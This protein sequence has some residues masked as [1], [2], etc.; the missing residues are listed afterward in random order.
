MTTIGYGDITPRNNLERGMC[1]LV[2]IAGVFIYSYIIGSIT[3][4]MADNE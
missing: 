4:M 1:I 2:M 3:S